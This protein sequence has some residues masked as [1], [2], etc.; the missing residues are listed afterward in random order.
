[1]SGL[2]KPERKG[3][4]LLGAQLHHGLQPITKEEKQRGRGLV[5]RGGP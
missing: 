3:Y 2:P 5:M 4:G 1:M